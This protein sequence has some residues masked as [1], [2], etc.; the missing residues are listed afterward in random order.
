MSLTKKEIE[1]VDKMI[2]SYKNTIKYIRSQIIALERKKLK[3]S[4]MEN[5]NIKIIKHKIKK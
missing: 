4:E 3:D 5:F 1:H 2:E